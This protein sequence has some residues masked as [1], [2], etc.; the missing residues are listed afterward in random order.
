MAIPSQFIDELRARVS[1]VDVVARRVKLIRR[2]HEHLGLCPFHKEKT[3][4]FR[5]Y[6][7]HFHCFGCQAHGGAIDFVMKAEGLPFREAVERLA[8]DA[9]MTVPDES[10]EDHERAAARKSLGEVV[11]KAAAYF[12]RM[13]R[14]PEGRE[15]LA[16]LRGRG[17]DDLAIARFRLGFAPD[18]RG[19]LK[20]DL[21][22]NGVSED[23]MVETGLMKRPE[24][25]RPPFDYFR[26]RVMFPISDRHGRPIAFGGRV[27]GP[28]EPKYLNSPETSLFQKGRVLYGLASALSPARKSG[29][30]I[31]AEGYMDVIALA[32]A[33]FENAVAPLGTALT[34]E[35]LAELWRTVPQPILCFDG[36]AAGQRAAGRAAER[37]LPLI[38]SGQQLRFAL[39]P[40]GEDPDSLIRSRGA[41][42]FEQVL[43]TALPLS[44][45]VWRLECPGAI[46]ASPEE[47][48][49]LQKRLKMQAQRITDADLRRQFLDFVGKRLWPRREARD[50]RP[51]PG[52]RSGDAP[53]NPLDIHSAPHAR[54]RLDRIRLHEEILLATLLAHPELFDGVG[55]RLG[56][57]SFASA[58]LDKA[59][60]EV[61]K[62]L[63][64]RH[65][66]DAAG[67]ER[68]LRDHGFSPVVDA[69]LSPQ[70][71]DHA[72]FAR[73]GASPDVAREGWEE[74][75]DLYR[76]TDLTAEIQDAQR[77]LAGDM[78]AE[79]N[80]YLQALK[81]DQHQAAGEG[82]SRTGTKS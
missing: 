31:V 20:A 22:R 26:N 66:L 11:D 8:Q 15:A 19:A 81:R 52:K 30:I 61:L 64:G 46:P 17:L 68:H 51:G 40:Q 43:E 5:V 50:R 3:P 10:P 72:F 35:H 2:G 76:Q 18:A 65:D 44:E 9:G 16:Y 39:M 27:M 62:T 21:A 38:R 57:L 24:D 55:E 54:I 82:V 42:A 79:T 28:G 41:G 7:D 75:L 60:Q 12:E 47:K 70:V 69:L 13:L 59:R 73:R 63:A 36:D 58:D 23:Q 6:E 77:R 1:V 45:V 56:T 78:S 32:T 33:G 80:D 71:L 25:G 4:S 53:A 49:A 34:E 74:T 14:M 29:R 67:L 37:A 48:A